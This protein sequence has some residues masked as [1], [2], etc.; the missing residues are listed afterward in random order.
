MAR[1][2]TDVHRPSTIDPADYVEVGFTDRHPE[3]GGTWIDPAYAGTLDFD[4][5]FT[6][7]GA[8]DHCG[9]HG[10]RYVAH[11]YHEPSDRIVSVGTTC[12]N[13]LNLPSKELVRMKR[14]A[15]R[16]AKARKV[17]KLAEVHP[18]V[19]ELI[20]W[21]EGVEAGTERG[22]EFYSSLFNQLHRKGELSEKQI[23]ALGKSFERKRE[24]ARQREEERA[25]EPDPAPV[26]VSDERLVITGKI[27][28]SKWKEGFY[29]DTLKMTVLDDR[30][31]KVWGTQPESLLVATD[32]ETDLGFIETNDYPANTPEA[33]VLDRTMQDGTPYKTAM[34]RPANRGDRVTFVAK[35]ER[36]DRDETFGFFKRPTKA[37][38]ID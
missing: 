28:S 21:H 15:E 12:A 24:W 36:S 6:Q 31:F 22:D 32:P 3:E 7:H 20:A 16:D 19:A 37:E 14:L 10:V 27:L 13:K 25:N 26:P 2:R 38:V 1:T 33:W 17:A 4:G 9:H 29:G 5:P 23:A 35:I 18:E 34:C 11:F 30:G 8:C